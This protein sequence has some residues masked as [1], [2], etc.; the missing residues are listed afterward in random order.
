MW[1][2]LA[3]VAVILVLRS[4]RQFEF[5]PT[6][7]AQSTAEGVRQKVAVIAKVNRIFRE[8]YEDKYPP[9]LYN[10]QTTFTDF[11]RYSY[12]NLD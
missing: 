11:L 6:G 9:F 12:A 4:Q 5:I 1:L 8:R 7:V 3:L 2:T 10:Y